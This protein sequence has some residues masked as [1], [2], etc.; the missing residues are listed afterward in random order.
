MS[1]QIC[2]L[3]GNVKIL[4]QANNICQLCLHKMPLYINYLTFCSSGTQPHPRPTL[5]NAH[6]LSKIMTRVILGSDSQMQQYMTNNTSKSLSLNSNA[7]IIYSRLNKS[8]CCPKDIKTIL[9]PYRL[10]T[11]GHIPYR[12]IPAITGQLTRSCTASQAGPAHVRRLGPRH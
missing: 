1:Q 7:P 3:W 11:A 5:G 2:C 8:S 9:N 4:E 6:L 12:R 10:D